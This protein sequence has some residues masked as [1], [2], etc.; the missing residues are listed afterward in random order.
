[1][2][3]EDIQHIKLKPQI[4]SFL[5]QTFDMLEVRVVVIASG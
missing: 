2:K 1:M 4:S 5:L 3:Q